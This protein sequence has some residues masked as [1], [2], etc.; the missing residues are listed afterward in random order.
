M[1]SCLLPV[2]AITSSSFG[3]FVIRNNCRLC[4]CVIKLLIN[5]PLWSLIGISIRPNECIDCRERERER[6]AASANREALL[7]S[8]SPAMCAVHSH[9]NYSKHQLDPIVFDGLKIFFN[10]QH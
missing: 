6:G 9:E 7:T 2:T 10:I 8:V 3:L 4:T 1:E 5:D